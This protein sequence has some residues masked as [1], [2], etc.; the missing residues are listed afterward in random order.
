MR[1]PRTTATGVASSQCCIVSLSVWKQFTN[2]QIQIFL[3]ICKCSCVCGCI[4][5][6]L[7]A[8]LVVAT[9]FAADMTIWFA[10]RQV[11]TNNVLHMLPS[12]WP[13]CT[14]QQRTMPL[15]HVKTHTRVWALFCLCFVVVLGYNAFRFT[16]ALTS[17][18]YQPF[19]I[20]HSQHFILIF[21][22][23]L[24]LCVWDIMWMCSNGFKLFWLS[25]FLQCTLSNW[26]W[27]SWKWM[28]SGYSCE[29][30]ENSEGIPYYFLVRFELFV[31]SYPLKQIITEISFL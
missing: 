11:H 10:V 27:S 29:G 23:V 19:K 5:Q 22:V 24:L 21:I 13:Q 2:A 3:C 15:L 25:I 8:V 17:M 12:Q 1:V 7:V 28:K 26:L 31:M 16:S 30:I 4:V 20:H 18:L 9:S 14:P 6:V